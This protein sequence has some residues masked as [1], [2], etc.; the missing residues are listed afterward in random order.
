MQALPAGSMLSVRLPAGELAPRLPAGVAIAAENAPGLCV[1]SGPTEAIAQLEA[2]L[3]AAGVTTRRLV[4]SHAFHSAMM[5]PVIEPLAARIAAV[6]LSPPRIP[7]V[8]TVTARWLTD[9]E[10]TSTRYWAEHLRLPVRFAPA[11]APC[12]PSRAAC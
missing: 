4:T 5:D 6:R 1:A 9:A 8:S 2:E 12:S 10:A 11:A 7:I 3:A